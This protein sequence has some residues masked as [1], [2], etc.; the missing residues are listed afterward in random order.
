LHCFTLVSAFHSR[1]IV[2]KQKKD[3]SGQVFTTFNEVV[4]PGMSRKQV[5]RR[6]FTLLSGFYTIQTN[7]PF[8]SIL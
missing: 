3:E 6:F 2:S 5:A 7:E 4:D 8:Q 1:A